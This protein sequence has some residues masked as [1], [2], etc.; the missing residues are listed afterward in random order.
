[1]FAT[2]KFQLTHIGLCIFLCCFV[3]FFSFRLVVSAYVANILYCLVEFESLDSDNIETYASRLI[4]YIIDRAFQ[5]VTSSSSVESRSKDSSGLE[6]LLS[7][8]GK[9]SGKKD[10]KV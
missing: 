1:M 5:T 7:Q 9:S 3:F 10:T 4:S 6:D 8:L 2:Y